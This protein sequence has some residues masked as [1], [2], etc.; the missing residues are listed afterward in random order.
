M[1]LEPSDSPKEILVISHL[2]LFPEHRLVRGGLI[3]H[4]SLKNL[5]R[6]GYKVS[7]LYYLPL[8][9]GYIRCFA[10]DFRSFSFK[11][12][13][14]DRISIHPVFYIPRLSKLS[15]AFDSLTKYWI[16]RLTRKTRQKKPTAIY[17]QTLYPDGPVA[18]KIAQ[19]LNVPFIVNLRGS[20]VHTFS[21]KI[22][23]VK[24]VAIPVLDKARKV[25]AVSNQL[26]LI[27]EQVFGYDYV[28][29]LLYTVCD[30]D[31]FKGNQAI[32][33]NLSSM[34]FVG[35]WVKAKGVFELFE[36]FRQ[37][38]ERYSGLRLTMIGSGSEESTLRSIAESNNFLDK[39]DF[40]GTVSDRKRLVELFNQSDIFVFPSYNEGLPNVVVEAVACE[41]AIIATNVGGVKEITNRNLG[42]QVIQKENV[43]AIV[44]AFE[45]LKDASIEEIQEDL[46]QN[47]TELISRFSPNAQLSSFKS[48]FGDL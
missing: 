39:I 15:P 21:A 37:L 38:Q 46:K 12:Y 45:R 11:P 29:R 18:E 4:N 26:K 16:F 44:N 8:T 31:V 43:E 48:V 20:D 28:D 47:R 27:A 10:F 36:A 24:A 6:L 30:V 34:L 1:N 19:F 35:A 7:V 2:Y 14:L 23:Q 17:S 25:L 42:F 41:R 32:N 3:I 22:D 33:P 5:L 9:V 13:E 40:V